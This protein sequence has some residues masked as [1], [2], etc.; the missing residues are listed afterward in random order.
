MTTNTLLE[1]RKT[2]W[3]NAKTSSMPLPTQTPPHHHDHHRHY[4]FTILL[5]FVFKIFYVQNYT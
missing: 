5:F 3:M 1:K 2:F 4:R